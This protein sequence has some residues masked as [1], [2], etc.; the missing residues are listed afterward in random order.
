MFGV[1][2]TVSGKTVVE[3]YSIGLYNSADSELEEANQYYYD[4]ENN[5][6]DEVVSFQVAPGSQQK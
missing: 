6:Y 4:A 1:A 5:L 3:E 2:G